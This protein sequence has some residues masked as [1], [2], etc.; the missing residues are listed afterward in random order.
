MV[1]QSRYEAVAVSSVNQ[2]ET[3]PDS[4]FDVIVI[5]HTLITE[6]CDLA[7][8]I[9]KTRWPGARIL[10]LTVDRSSCE[11]FADD[12]TRGLDGP[13]TL[14]SRIDNLIPARH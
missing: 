11:E 10:A 12:S 14:L 6:E 1:L 4:H 5:C 8:S 13:A 7:V 9:C 2:I 3:L